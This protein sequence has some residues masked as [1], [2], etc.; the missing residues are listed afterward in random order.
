MSV[1][2]AAGDIRLSGMEQENEFRFSRS[3]RVLHRHDSAC[4]GEIVR[5]R[6][7]DRRRLRRRHAMRNEFPDMFLHGILAA[8]GIAGTNDALRRE[9]QRAWFGAAGDSKMQHLFFNHL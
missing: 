5:Y 3:T 2:A 9:I 4:C 8:A 7:E 6:K 1:I